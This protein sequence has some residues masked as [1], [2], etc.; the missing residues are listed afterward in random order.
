MILSLVFAAAA[1]V[2]PSENGRALSLRDVIARVDAFDPLLR[3]RAL[4]LVRA[5]ITLRRAEWNRVYGGIGI[6]AQ[7]TLTEGQLAAYPK[8]EAGTN[9]AITPAGTHQLAAYLSAQVAFPLYAGGAISGAIDAAEARAHAANADLVQL[10]RDLRRVALTAYAQLIASRQQFEVASHALARGQSLV[11]LAGR[12]RNSGLGTESDVARAKLN[13]LREQEDLEQRRGDEALAQAAVRAVLLLDPGTMVVPSD[14]MSDIARYQSGGP[15]LERPELRSLSEQARAAEY[16][17]KVAF[18]GYLPRLELFADAT[19]GNGSFI[20]Y[21]GVPVFT[22]GTTTY[23]GNFTG[24]LS[25]GA[26]VSWTFFD[27]F[28]TRD[29]VAQAAATRDQVSARL[30]DEERVV[31]R[32]RDEARAREEQG[33]RRMEALSGGGET[34]ALSVKL[35]R[36][37]YE[38]GNAI[39]TEVLDAEIEAIGIEARQVQAAY[40]FATAHLDRLRADGGPL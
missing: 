20:T 27:F 35:A 24:T 6:N 9:L 37:R 19:Y 17:R 22:G 31:A 13:L 18:A 2:A 25:A 21:A 39:L 38:S 14:T 16:D 7:D 40:D 8:T 36:A 15:V 1:V 3:A 32:E 28:I 26:R 34:A 4:D 5:E 33:R 11:D 29:G 12:R 10:K 30:A 23:L